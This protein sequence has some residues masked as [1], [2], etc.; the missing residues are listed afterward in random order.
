M[1]ER[2][3]VTRS[4]EL[5]LEPDHVWELIGDGERWADWMV[6]AADVEVAP[7]GGGTVVDGDESRDVRIDTVDAGERVTFDWWPVG[8]PDEASSVELRIVPAVSRTVLEVVE[9]FPAGRTTIAMSAAAAT[10]RVRAVALQASRRTLV[11]A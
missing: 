11:A 3:D 2:V 10:W 6:D 4:I 5:D 9:T 1:T 8:R 7:G